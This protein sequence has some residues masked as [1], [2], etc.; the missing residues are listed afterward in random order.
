MAISVACKCGQKFKANESM[1]GKS[2]KCPKCGGALKIPKPQSTA[3]APDPLGGGGLDDLLGM[4][5]PAQSS[6]P[7]TGAAPDIGSLDLADLD[8]GAA[9]M[10]PAGLD[11]APVGSSPLETSPMQSPGLGGDPLGAAPA[12]TM[13]G[14]PGGAAAPSGLAAS[15]W[16]TQ[17]A[18]QGAQKKEKKGLSRTM[19]IIL[20]GGGG[21]VLVSVV[22]VVA[23][24]F[25]GGG[26]GVASSS[27]GS[28]PVNTTDDSA[29][30]MNMTDGGAAAVATTDGSA[31]ATDGSG[32]SDTDGSGAATDSTPQKTFELY[33]AAREKKNGANLLALLDEPSQKRVLFA[34]LMVAIRDGQQNAALADFLRSHG[35]QPQQAYALLTKTL[36][37]LEESPDELAQHVDATAARITDPS[38]FADEALKNIRLLGLDPDVKSDI[39]DVEITG[40]K[41]KG[42]E[43]SHYTGQDIERS[44]EFRLVKGW[45][46]IHKP[47]LDTA[48]GGYLKSTDA[49]EEAAPAENP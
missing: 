36:D 33:K 37:L 40:D 8:L 25:S 29:A 31:A 20:A 42:I 9:D 7:A 35:F 21:L 3:A 39:K 4:E 27:D 14:A 34:L 44:I 17:P 41:A 18:Q 1:A 49:G 47:D 45:W 38:R 28:P 19:L 43:V 10:G 5:M 11:S 46:Y 32:N 48:S 15:P 30:A 26:N 2:V 24:M 22:V 23:I 12:G 13:G 6:G 16:Q